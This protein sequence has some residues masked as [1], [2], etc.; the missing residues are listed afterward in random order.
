MA[1]SNVYDLL[2]ALPQLEVN[3]SQP[4]A[5]SSLEPDWTD[6]ET[7]EQIY[8][9]P[10][11]LVHAGVGFNTEAIFTRQLLE[12]IQSNKNAISANLR[13]RPRTQ[14]QLDVIYSTAV[15]DFEVWNSDEEE[16]FDENVHCVT[17]RL[18]SRVELHP[19]FQSSFWK[20]SKTNRMLRVTNQLQSRIA[21]FQ[22]HTPL[23][24][25]TRHRTMSTVT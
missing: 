10:F 8:S 4:N 24:W 19:G 25:D 23:L 6:E 7:Q 5:V 3:E 17:I 18:M 9:V 11:N 1:A 20:I 13:K 2:A 12:D 21:G 15:G 22:Y 16:D 14:R